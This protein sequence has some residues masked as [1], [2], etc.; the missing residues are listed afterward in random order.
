MMTQDPKEPKE[1]RVES[2]GSD[3]TV[4]SQAD[5]DDDLLILGG[6]LA[7]VSGLFYR[8]GRSSSRGR[9]SRS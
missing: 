8:P 1:P 2:N 4:D 9:R 5:E 3:Q 7:V 6:G